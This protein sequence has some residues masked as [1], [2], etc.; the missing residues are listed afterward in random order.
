MFGLNQ[1]GC[2]HL[3]TWGG[4][5]GWEAVIHINGE[6][7]VSDVHVFVQTQRHAVT[8]LTILLPSPT[9]DCFF[10]LTGT[11]CTQNTNTMIQFGAVFTVLRVMSF[12]SRER[13]NE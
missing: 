9:C 6:L 13:I 8:L 2:P 7:R 4:V 10:V 1:M 11:S 3:F 5:C 12:S